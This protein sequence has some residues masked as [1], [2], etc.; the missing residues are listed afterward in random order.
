MAAGVSE[1]VI[2]DYLKKPDFEDR[3]KAARDDIVRGVSNH[4]REQMN[5]AVDIIGDIMRAPENRAQDRL[6]AAKAVLEFGDR[7]I[8]NDDVLGRITKLE[9]SIDSESE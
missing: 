6:A 2:Y 3:Y 4:L 5:E 1:R 9:N 7:Y 8:E